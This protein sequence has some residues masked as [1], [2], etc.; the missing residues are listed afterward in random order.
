MQPLYRMAR[1]EATLSPA[2]ISR[3]VSQPRFDPQLDDLVSHEM[4]SPRGHHPVT[5]EENGNGRLNFE[6][7]NNACRSSSPKRN[8]LDETIVPPRPFKLNVKCCEM[9]RLRLRQG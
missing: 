9:Q 8:L 3:L 2:H 6:I 5:R 4:S 1:M 7:I